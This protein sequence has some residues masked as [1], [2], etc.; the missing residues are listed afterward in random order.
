[1][2]SCSY[3]YHKSTNVRCIFQ[4]YFILI[5]VN[6]QSKSG[7]NNRSILELQMDGS[8]FQQTTS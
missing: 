5:D 4:K 8:T 2:K 3:M 1:M 7:E 6:W